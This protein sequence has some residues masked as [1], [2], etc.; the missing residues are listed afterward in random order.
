MIDQQR[1]DAIA[2]FFAVKG[3]SRGLTCPGLK[4]E[5]H[6]GMRDIWIACEHGNVGP[7][8]LPVPDLLAD[9]WA[10]LTQL[11]E[12]GWSV[13]FEREDEAVYIWLRGSLKGSARICGYNN[14]PPKDLGVALL[15]AAGQVM[16]REKERG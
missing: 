12:K 7:H 10:L 14:D 5:R 4:E 11:L 8:P 16:D 3:W 6:F 9:P 15:D 2:E 13:S 1:H